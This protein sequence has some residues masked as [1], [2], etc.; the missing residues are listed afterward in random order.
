[1]WLKSLVDPE[2]ALEI[3][4]GSGVLAETLLAQWPDCRLTCTD[5]SP[6]ALED[7]GKR[8]VTSQASLLL[9]DGFSHKAIMQYAPYELIVC[10][11]LAEPLLAWEAPFRQA[12]APGGYLLL[13]G[14]LAWKAE[15]VIEAYAACGWQKQAQWNMREWGAVAWQKPAT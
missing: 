10:N 6:K 7:T 15:G 13:S 2:N 1:M 14:L 9:S 11:M 4:C 3:G 12:C 5:I 8:L